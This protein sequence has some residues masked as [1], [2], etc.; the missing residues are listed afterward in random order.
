ME[1]AVFAFFT[2]V[3]L[4]MWPKLYQ[5][6]AFLGWIFVLSLGVV[7]PLCVIPIV[8][9]IRMRGLPIGD[10]LALGPVRLRP[11]LVWLGLASLLII[12]MD[13]TSEW[14]GVPIPNF[15]SQVYEAADPVPL[16]WPAITVVA[17]ICEEI[18]FRGFM[19]EGLRRSRIGPIGA[20][21]VTS[22]LWAI[23]HFQ[24]GWFE[25]LAIVALGVLFGAARLRT[26]SLAVPIAMHCLVNVAA[27]VQIV[28]MYS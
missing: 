5:G 10:Y 24:Y 21:L 12:A 19:M 8:I 23:V 27:S 15:L 7:R 20:V 26:N 22:V 11:L 16:L 1:L 28:V 9:F 14:L 2:A 13:L 25:I 17:P 3:T 4:F 6:P 18:F